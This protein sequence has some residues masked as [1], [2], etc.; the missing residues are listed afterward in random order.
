MGQV[1]VQRDRWVCA[2]TQWDRWVSVIKRNVAVN[3]FIQHLIFIEKYFVPKER[4][5]CSASG[6][7]SVVFKSGAHLRRVQVLTI[8]SVGMSYSNIILFWGR[9]YPYITRMLRLELV[10]IHVIVFSDWKRVRLD[11]EQWVTCLYFSLSPYARYSLAGVFAKISV[12]CR[13]EVD[14]SFSV[15]AFVC[16]ESRQLHTFA[17]LTLQYHFK[18]F[19]THLITVADCNRN[20]LPCSRSQGEIFGEWGS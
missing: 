1:S 9:L 4:R 15:L 11:L 3:L 16:S 2:L 20:K 10:A 17:N 12:F 5:P 13:Y 14:F 6:N 18:N 8:S 7:F 19:H